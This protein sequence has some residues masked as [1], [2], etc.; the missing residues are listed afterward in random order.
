MNTLKVQVTSYGQPLPGALVR[1]SGDDA[2]LASHPDA[3]LAV[4]DGITWTREIRD[5]SGNRW[6]CWQRHVAQDVAGITWQE[7]REQ[8]LVHNPSLGETGGQF[9][10]GRLYFLPENRLPANIAPWWCGIEP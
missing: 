4:N 7:F 10:A 3:V 2:G 5:Y 6:N 8:V 1:L 9:E